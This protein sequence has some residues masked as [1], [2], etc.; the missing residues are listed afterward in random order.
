MNMT[1]DHRFDTK[2][3]FNE[4]HDGYRE[5][6]YCIEAD[7]AK[8][9]R[10]IGIDVSNNDSAQYNIL[11]RHDYNND[12]RALI[13]LE[14]I[15]DIVTETAP[16]NMTYKNVEVKWHEA[17]AIFGKE[18]DIEIISFRQQADRSELV[19][20]IKKYMNECIYSHDFDASQCVSKK[21]DLD[22]QQ[23]TVNNINEEEHMTYKDLQKMIGESFSYQ[24]DEAAKL[25]LTGYYD[26]KEIELDFDK[27]DERIYE[28]LNAGD[29]DTEYKDAMRILHGPKTY[30]FDHSELIVGNYYSCDEVKLNFDFMTEK[31]FEKLHCTEDL[32]D[33]F[34]RAIDS[35]K[36][37]NNMQM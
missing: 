27:M 11:I 37:E 26:G 23:E 5:I 13:N 22:E 32:D 20:Q 10:D 1:I 2:D 4:E 28:D 31:I 18:L 14:H 12:E 24:F 33:D 9:Y 3:G 19:N 30:E 6:G 35:I 15:K 34:S 7:I 36:T 21:K 17:D 29:T 25:T 16:E 8:N